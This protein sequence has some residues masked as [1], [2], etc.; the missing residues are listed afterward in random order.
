M[1]EVID[2]TKYLKNKEQDELDSLAQRLADLIDD[3]GITHEY[4]MYIEDENYVYGMPS[5][6][7]MTPAEYS[8]QK[9][10]TL[11]DVTDALTSITLSLDEMGYTNWANQISSVVGEMFASGTFGAT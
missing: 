5:V 7:T 1:G 2:I 6:Y 11:S 3:L 4:E 9:V 8:S 10:E